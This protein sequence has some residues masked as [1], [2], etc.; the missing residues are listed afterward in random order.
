MPRLNK[1]DEILFDVEEHP[2]FVDYADREGRRHLP[3]PEKK[4][5]VARHNQRVLGIVN[6]DYRLVSNREALDMAFRCCRAAFP[7]TKPAEWEVAGTDAPATASYCH[8][9]LRHNSTA[10]DFRFLPAAERPEVFGPFIRVSNSYNGMRALAFD[11]GFYRKI[12][13]NG[14]I[15]PDSIIRFKFTHDRR[16]IGEAIE[17]EVAHEKLAKFKASF[18]VLLG[19]LR[20]CAVSRPESYRLVR[21]VLRFRQPD[22]LKPD[23][24]LA[25]DWRKLNASLNEMCDRYAG[26]LGENAYAVFNA[27]T[28]LASHP[29]TNRCVHRDRH[30]LQRLAGAWVNDFN[31]QR[32]A[33]NFN[34]TKHIEK[35]EQPESET[36][37]QKATRWN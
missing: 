17:F 19:G 1:L 11:I 10:L 5:I 22:P 26:E 33:P 29:P 37:E 21:A 25:E 6:R 16:D 18:A 14:M 30:S 32:P 27:I 23:S 24:P 28:E 20:G 3:V 13:T 34:L 12:C 35:L 9:D 8:I 2:V 4:A 31:R 15:L 7:E 36:E